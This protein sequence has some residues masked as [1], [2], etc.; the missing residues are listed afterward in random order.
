[1][2]IG[3][4][5]F[6]FS[7][8]AYYTF[9]IGGYSVGPYST[10]DYSFSYSAWHFDGGTFIGWFA[11]IV[12]L[13]AAAAVAIQLFVPAANLPMA[14]RVLAVIL[15][16]VSLVLYIIGIFAMDVPAGDHGFSYWLSLVL[17]AAGLVLSLMRAQ[18]TGTALPGPLANMP[19]IGPRHPGGG[20][21]T[22]PPPPPG[23]AP[24]PPPPGY[25]PPPAP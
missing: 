13:L 16:A 18:Q 2:G 1:L 4:V 21:G 12:G 19:N 11:M 23:Y 14:A 10:P 8:F 5:L 25:T 6:I 24:P 22:P 7:F 15:F 17:V 3:A 20:P 9:S